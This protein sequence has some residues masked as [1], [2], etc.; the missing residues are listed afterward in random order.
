MTSSIVLFL[1]KEMD[2]KLMVINEGSNQ[3]I[4]NHPGV[5]NSSYQ[6]L[7]WKE[8]TLKYERCK[9]ILI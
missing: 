1:L 3:K 8:A 9:C 5:N 6:A 2:E 7:K 4:N